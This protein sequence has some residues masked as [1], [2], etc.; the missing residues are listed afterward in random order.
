[1]KQPYE[2]VVNIF[3]SPNMQKNCFIKT[4]QDISIMCVN[5]TQFW[6]QFGN[7]TA[8]VMPDEHRKYMQSAMVHCGHAYFFLQ[9]DASASYVCQLQYK[10]N[11][12]HIIKFIRKDWIAHNVYLFNSKTHLIDYTTTERFLDQLGGK[13]VYFVRITHLK[14]Y[15]NTDGFLFIQ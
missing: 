3:K 14:K 15:K 10:G 13:E 4:K 7:G 8:E 6:T 9:K 11:K 1:M 12:Y 5:Q 2:I